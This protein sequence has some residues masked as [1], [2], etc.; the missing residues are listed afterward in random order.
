MISEGFVGVEGFVSVD[1]RRGGRTIQ[2]PVTLERLGW[3]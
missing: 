2:E 3:T 1:R